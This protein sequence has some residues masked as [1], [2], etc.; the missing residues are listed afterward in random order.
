MTKKQQA[1]INISVMDSSILYATDDVIEEYRDRLP[2]N[3][4]PVADL[5]RMDLDDDRV[6]SF[7]KHGL[8]VDGGGW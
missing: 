7:A 4:G 8:K 5:C 2:N 6:G 1:A 3:Y